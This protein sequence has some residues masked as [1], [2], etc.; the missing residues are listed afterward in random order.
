MHPPSTVPM[1]QMG[2][3]SKLLFQCCRLFFFCFWVPFRFKAQVIKI[4]DSIDSKV[5]LIV[6]LVS[7]GSMGI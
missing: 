7:G 2:H 1:D 3:L 4:F 5:T 6:L